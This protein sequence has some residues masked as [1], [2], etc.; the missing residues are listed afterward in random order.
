MARSTASPRRRSNQAPASPA[1]AVSAPAVTPPVSSTMPAQ[2]AGTP[3]QPAATGKSAAT[4]KAAPARKPAGAKTP[5][6]ASKAAAAQPA[7]APA[8]PAAAKKAVVLPPPPPL[9]KTPPASPAKADKKATKQRPVLVRDSF[10]MPEADFALI[11]SLKSS[12]LGA[13]RAA[14]KSEL[15]RAGLRLLAT[16]DAQSL[17][18]ALDRLEPVTTGR[19]KK[20]H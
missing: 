20:G 8:K 14:K 1:A 2:A 15:L 16:L 6:A 4:Q 18:A 10:T 9:A 3:K 12:A 7:K 19:P 17:V 11:A 5:A 13:R